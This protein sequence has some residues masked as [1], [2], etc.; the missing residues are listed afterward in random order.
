MPQISIMDN[1][2]LELDFCTELLQYFE[3]MNS[4][5]YNFLECAQV[6]YSIQSTIDSYFNG[7]INFRGLGHG[8]NFILWH[9]LLKRVFQL[10]QKLP[11]M[12][13]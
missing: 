10:T 7:N 4:E 13:K 3:D 9:F 2:I 1:N 6:S 11:I 12:K 8:S 5:F